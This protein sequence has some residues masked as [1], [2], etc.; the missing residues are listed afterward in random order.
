MSGKGGSESSD[1]VYKEVDNMG[2]SLISMSE[3][4]DDM[5]A[6][7]NLLA[8]SIQNRIEKII[9]I[10]KSYE[11]YNRQLGYTYN[12]KIAS[13]RSKDDVDEH[14]EVT[15]LDC[16]HTS[17]EINQSEINPVSVGDTE[18]SK[19][20]LISLPSRAF[21]E[22]QSIVSNGSSVW[23]IFTYGGF[24]FN[25]KG[26]LVHPRYIFDPG[27]QKFVHATNKPTRP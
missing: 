12:N 1:N 9:D 23:K 13:F 15:T 20:S 10:L 19:S 3:F 5:I 17:E 18:T 22:P 14:H 25:S 27:I 2:H 7:L 8:R 24:L 26:A 6:H 11:I 16:Q 21:N 4:R